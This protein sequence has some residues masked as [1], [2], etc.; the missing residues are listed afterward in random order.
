VSNR[1]ENSVH[2]HT[3]LVICTTAICKKSVYTAFKKCGIAWVL[4]IS[5]RRVLFQRIYVFC[6]KNMPFII[7]ALL[8][9]SSRS[10]NYGW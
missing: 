8:E 4:G 9:I 1:K 3:V 5:K 10:K 6:N 2:N 7:Y